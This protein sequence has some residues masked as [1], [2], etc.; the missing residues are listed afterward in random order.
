MTKATLIKGNISLGM[1]YR[2]R[3]LIHYHHSGK[4]WWYPDRRGAGEEAESSTS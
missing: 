4:A 1:G 2:F 3:S